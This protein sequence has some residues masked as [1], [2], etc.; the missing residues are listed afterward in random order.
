MAE[1]H[2]G[3]WLLDAFRQCDVDTNRLARDFPREFGRILDYP[4]TVTLDELNLVLNACADQTGDT[5]FGLH[6]VERVP[7]SALGIFAYVLFNAPT[8]GEFLTL[9][10]RYYPIF[11]RGAV[12]EV[13]K[14][15]RICRVVY[16]RPDIPRVSQRHDTE[17]TMG[18]FVHTIR[19]KLGTDWQPLRVTFQEPEPEDVS[20]LTRFFGSNL[21]YDYPVN[22]FEIDPGSLDAPLNESDPHLLQI[23]MQQADALLQSFAT[24]ESIESHVRLLIMKD[25]ESGPPNAAHIARQMGMSL[26]TLKR[27]LADRKLTFRGLRDAVVRELA[28]QALVETDLRISQVAMQL[29]YSEVSGFNHAF[30]RLVGQSPREYRRNLRQA[31]R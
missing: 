11:Y 4:D 15:R 27:R 31:D 1:Q 6:L 9:A 2:P 20:K 12:L 14:Q 23:M 26:S 21:V 30:T 7:S 16:R 19:K 10:D 5:H 25:I 24:T 8:I 28:K 3:S 29:G 13:R 18:F 17:W 22:S